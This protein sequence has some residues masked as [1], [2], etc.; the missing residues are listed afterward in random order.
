MNRITKKDDDNIYRISGFTT[1]D[2]LI[3]KL[4]IYEDLEEE[5]GCPLEKLIEFSKQET[6]YT[7]LG[8]FTNEI[9]L[10]DF[11]LGRIHITKNRDLNDMYLL[12]ISDYKKTWWLKEDRSE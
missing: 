4:A 7:K 5:L 11:N 8:A 2:E 6:V 9:V 3:D 1:R 12:Y 10:V